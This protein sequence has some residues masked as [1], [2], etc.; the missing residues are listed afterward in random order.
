MVGPNLTTITPHEPELQREQ[1]G[2]GRFVNHVSPHHA[3][4]LSGG[5][6]LRIHDPPPFSTSHVQTCIEGPT[7][8]TLTRNNRGW[9]C[10]KDVILGPK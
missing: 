7:P 4:T 6:G 9:P 2:D 3:R 5:S 1:H 10:F 8:P